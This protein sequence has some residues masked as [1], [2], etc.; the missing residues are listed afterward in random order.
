[1]SKPEYVVTVV[2]LTGGVGPSTYVQGGGEGRTMSCY[3]REDLG[4]GEK[5][6]TLSVKM[7]GICQS[8]AQT[9]S[10]IILKFV[11]S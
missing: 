5:E 4:R 2:R 1:M 6:R 8:V 10:R 11:V 3:D 7:V 9:F